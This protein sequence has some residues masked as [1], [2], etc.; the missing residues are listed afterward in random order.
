MS[1]S[2]PL[3]KLSPQHIKFCEKYIFYYI[4]G[5]K[6]PGKLAAIASKYSKDNAEKQASTLLGDPLIKQYIANRSVEIQKDTQL[7]QLRLIEECKSI[8]FSNIKDIVSFDG[9]EPIYKSFD[10]L[11]RSETACISGIKK[12]ERFQ[13]DGTRVVETDLKTESKAAARKDL[14]KIY[15]LG[16]ENINVKGEVSQQR[17]DFS[18]WDK[19][20]ILDFIKS[21]REK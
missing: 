11:E 19:K 21:Q 9:V 13:P 7:D 1:K 2:K 12:I 15:E 6:Q 14:I 3:D 8:A 5:D 20:E 16:S 17:Y 18:G 10:G 4:R